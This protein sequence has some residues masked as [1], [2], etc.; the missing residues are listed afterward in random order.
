MV[1]T[2]VGITD[3][4]ARRAAV[5][6]LGRRLS[7][8]ASARSFLFFRARTLY[9]ATR[10]ARGCFF[11][12]ES[13]R[14]RMRPGIERARR[15]HRRA[16]PAGRALALPSFSP[17]C[18]PS[19]LRS[20]CRHVRSNRSNVAL[21]QRQGVNRASGQNSTG[22]KHEV[23]FAVQKSPQPCR[24]RDQ[25]VKPAAQSRIGVTAFRGG[26][27]DL[28]LTF[29]ASRLLDLRADKAA[30]SCARPSPARAKSDPRTWT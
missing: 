20:P 1:G 15:S 11:A 7:P 3:H 27:R 18:S 2:A 19:A 26:R 23:L 6:T 5:A 28:S 8:A 12:T 30:T 10:A 25:L 14:R 16:R 24:T 13:S 22:I 9:S 21:T 4:T 29:A 17:P